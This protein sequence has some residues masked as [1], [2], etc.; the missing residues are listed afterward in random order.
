MEL[1]VTS[2]TWIKEGPLIQQESDGDK[3]VWD[4]E[5]RGAREAQLPQR[6]MNLAHDSQKQIQ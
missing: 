1:P 6:A 5:K 3:S 2:S 4:L